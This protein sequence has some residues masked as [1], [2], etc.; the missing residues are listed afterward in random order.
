MRRFIA[1]F[2]DH[3]TF[4]RESLRIRDK[5]G[6]MVPLTLAPAQLKLWRG[7]Q[8][9]RALGVPVRICYLK[10]SQVMVSSG[11]AAEFFHMVPFFPGRHC[12]AVADSEQHASLVF[13]YYTTFQQ[14][15]VPFGDSLESSIR[16]PELVNDKGEMLKWANDS[17]IQVA[18][19]RNP[20]VGRSHPW[21]FAQISEFG[22]IDHGDVLMNGLM[23]RVP[24]RP[25]TAVVVESTAF[26]EGGPFYDLCM[27]A[28][29]P[30]RAGGWLFLFFGWHEHPEYSTK[31]PDPAGFQ[32]DLSRD[33]R[34]EQQKYNLTLDQLWWRR[35]AIADD[36]GGRVENFRQEHPGNPREAFQSSGKKYFDL[37]TVERCCQ[38]EEP[39]VG[40]VEMF[41]MGPERRPQ[42]RPR[43]DGSL[44]LYRRP[45]KNGRYT[46]GGDA[47]QGKD[48][49]LKKGGNTDPDYASLTVIDADTGEQVAKWRGRVNEALLGKV[50]YALGWYYG[51]AFVVP[52]VVGHGRAFLQA[53]L[54]EGYPADRIYRKQRVAGDERPPTFNEMG[55][56]TN[57][58]NRPI[59]LSTLD[60][61]F[62]QG[63]ITVHD[64]GT[65]TECRT[66]INNDGRG[67]AKIGSHDD[68]VLSLALGWQGLKQIPAG[69]VVSAAERQ[70]Q[71]KP[72]R[73]GRQ[74]D[75]DDE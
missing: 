74:S 46:I 2:N 9:Q 20:H 40:E 72:V 17:F 3:P 18:T 50:A 27:R 15:Y 22:F 57:E 10:A 49:S 16:L 21:Q 41:E 28:M 5:S 14:N 66:F 44:F 19:G 33:E 32:R 54:A 59:L 75:E 48:P 62:L 69:P 1:G 67:E 23:Q 25:D 13:N 64:S 65:A 30:V 36:C 7:I 68:D 12:L 63:A 60:T 45:K 51:W 52:E 71:W 6:A 47:C 24:K 53:L 4:A 35:N 55:F 61:A 73:Y 39:I 42:F 31:C 56:E 26:G 29:D 11:T 70:Q 38:I 37:A 8:K 58:V 43:E 34:E